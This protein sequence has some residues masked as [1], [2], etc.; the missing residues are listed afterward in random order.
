ML[1]V[2]VLSVQSVGTNTA[3]K[4]VHASTDATVERSLTQPL[5]RGSYLTPVDKNVAVHWGQNV[6][7]HAICCVTQVTGV[8]VTDTCVVISI[9]CIWWVL[10]PVSDEL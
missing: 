3:R 7:T 10:R 6:V 8:I 4:I 1:N 5:I 2:A 9:S